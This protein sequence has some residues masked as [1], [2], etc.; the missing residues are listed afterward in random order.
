MEMK[1][2]FFSVV[3]L[4][5]APNLFS[6]GQPFS[7]D[8]NQV[9]T[10]YDSTEAPHYLVYNPSTQRNKLFLWLGGTYSNP[11]LYFRICRFAGDLGF[12]VISLSYPNDVP[13]APLGADPDSTIFER[14][15]QEICFGT[16]VSN[17]VAVDTLNSIYVRTIKLLQYLDTNRPS[18]NWGQYLSGPDSMNWSNV[19][20]GGHSQGSGHAPYL[21]KAFPVDRC[22]MFSGPNDYSTV[23]NIGAP[24][25]AWQGETGPNAHFAYLHLQDDVV[26][27]SNQYADLGRLGL[28]DSTLVDPLS[29]PYNNAHL[30]YTNQPAQP[31]I[32]THS[33]PVLPPTAIN[34][35][36]WEYMLTT[37][38]PV[39]VKEQTSADLRIYPVPARDRVRI[40]GIR[41][42]GKLTV[43]NSLG[44]QVY[45]GLVGPGDAEL[46]ILDW[47]PGVYF[48][49]TDQG[50]FEFLIQ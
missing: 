8:P 26:D 10:A 36:V 13:V 12:H 41:E 3:L 31:F 40:R 38:I 39:G 5:I 14:F 11:N 37:T 30:L 21:A 27:F 42:H 33:M 48:L 2:L 19:I 6:Q 23:Y 49:R 20:V 47:T 25:F 18:E 46:D 50:A 9:D 34:E 15:R 32:G 35:P 7:I 24:W 17:E 45:E 28:S 22:L 4:L 29:P 1:P 43:W 16:P 44:Q